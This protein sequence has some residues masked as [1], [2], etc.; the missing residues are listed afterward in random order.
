MIYKC[1]GQRP[2]NCDSENREVCEQLRAKMICTQRFQ[3]TIQSTH[4]EQPSAICSDNTY[5][6]LCTPRET[7]SV[8]NILH[9]KRNNSAFAGYVFFHRSFLEAISLPSNES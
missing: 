7:Q 8:K 5:C 3:R 6:Y 1:S 4:T 9:T 2:I